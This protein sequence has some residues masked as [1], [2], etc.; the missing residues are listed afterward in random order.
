MKSKKHI[1]KQVRGIIPAFANG[2]KKADNPIGGTFLSRQ[3]MKR[4]RTVT[5]GCISKF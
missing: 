1:V 3:N 4:L 5:E 2:Q